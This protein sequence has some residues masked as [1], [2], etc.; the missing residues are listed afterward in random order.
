V[1]DKKFIFPKFLSTVRIK[2]HREIPENTE[3]KRVTISR[4]QDRYF[5]SILVDD[6]QEKPKS[7]KA[8]KAIGL[9][10]GIENFIIT[11]DGVKFENKRYFDKK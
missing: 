10:M 11:S 9:D 3:L 2:I 4:V 6:L 5:A 7:I 8:K 1:G